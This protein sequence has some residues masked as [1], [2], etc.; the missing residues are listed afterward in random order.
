[1][2]C[3]PGLYLTLAVCQVCSASDYEDMAEALLNLFASRGKLVELLVAVIE[4]EVAITGT[5]V[6]LLRKP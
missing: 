4:H 6:A 2:L 1:M 5:H 3:A